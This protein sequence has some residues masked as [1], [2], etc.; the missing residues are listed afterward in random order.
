MLGLYKV[1]V[2]LYR[3]KVKKGSG[4]GEPIGRYFFLFSLELCLKQLVARVTKQ[5]LYVQAYADNLA[6]LFTGA[7]MIWITCMAQKAIQIAAN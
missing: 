3:D 4:K 7:D 1:Q 6:V 5:G 2:E